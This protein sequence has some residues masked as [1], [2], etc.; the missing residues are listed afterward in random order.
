MTAFPANLHTDAAGIETSA[1]YEAG[2]WKLYGKIADGDDAALGAVA[3][4][5]VTDPAASGSVVALLKGI[6]TRLSAGAANLLKTEDTAAAAG[7]AGVAVLAVRRDTPASG[8]SADGDYALLSVDDVG[9]LRTAPADPADA[10]NATTTALATN[11]VVKGSAGTLY[12]FQ[13]YHSGASDAY[14]QI[15]DAATLPADSAVPDVVIPVE[16]GKPFSL[17][18]GRRG[19]TFDT[20]I[21]ACLSTTG[22]TKTLGS[23]EA[24]IDAQY[25]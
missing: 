16:A 18:F 2:Q 22:P 5:A 8:V 10:S 25:A 13:G 9:Q 6:L 23:A 7:S 20:G 14:I 4:A 21:V 24:W 11:L 1:I 19:R 15:H 12:G 3:D 17:D